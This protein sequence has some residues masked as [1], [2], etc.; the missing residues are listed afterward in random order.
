[1][2]ARSRLTLFSALLV[3]LAVTRIGHFGTVVS[4]PDASLAVFLLGG[5]WLGGLRCFAAYAAT[6][7]AIDVFLAK[8]A[9]EAGW[10]LT[11]GYA[12]LVA[13]YAS[14]WLF[15]RLLARTPELPVMRY[16]GIGIAAV[17][18]HFLIANLSF[19]ALSGYFD[20]MSLSDYAASVAKYL[21]PYLAST[22][23]Y[24]ALAW[25]GQRVL[26]TRLAGRH[27]LG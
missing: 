6:A 23:L 4:L 26:A 8:N 24:L 10:C 7:F 19:W 12:G 18:V 20:A 25:V 14:V 3:L 15:G 21:P 16:A 11:P 22:A 5:L 1:M 17:L 2:P 13:A 27:S 9:V